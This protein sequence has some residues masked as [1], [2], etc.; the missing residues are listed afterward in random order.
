MG[1]L[2]MFSKLMEIAPW[3]KY[4]L[5][6]L[7]GLVVIGGAVVSATP[8]KSDDKAWDKI[9]KY[10]LVGPLLSILANFSPIQKKKK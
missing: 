6:L 3:L 9:K 1:N 2:D 7:G 8:S 10:P 4:I 5:P